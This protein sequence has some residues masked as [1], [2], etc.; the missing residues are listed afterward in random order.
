[1]DELITA[2]PT[3]ISAFAA[4]NLDDLVILTLF[5]SRINTSFRPWH[6]VVGQYLGFS[7]LVIASLSGFFGSMILPEHWIG[8]MGLIPIAIGFSHWLNPE[9]DFSEDSNEE[10]E[11]PPNSVFSSLLSPQIY[12]VAAITVVNGSDNISIYVPLFASTDL[13][14]LLII[15]GVFF[16]LVGVWCYASYK[17][18]NQSAIADVLTR[19]GSSLVPFVLVGLGV[20][21]ILQSHALNPLA[22][23]VCCLCLIGIVKKYKPSVEVEEN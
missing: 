1:M 10:T 15:L 20:F 23:G 5:F 21:I 13:V 9:S 14:K 7:L 18:M 2:I 6:I 3:G 4:T 8:L 19:Y 16:L 11:K 22:L 17:L 12:S